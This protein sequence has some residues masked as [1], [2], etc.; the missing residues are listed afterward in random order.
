MERHFNGAGTTTKGPAKSDSTHIS[1]TLQEDPRPSDDIPR[2]P[3]IRPTG[4]I[5]TLEIVQGGRSLGEVHDF[6]V[7]REIRKGS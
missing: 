4:L 3:K 6:N 7:C 5:N 1:Q 2:Y